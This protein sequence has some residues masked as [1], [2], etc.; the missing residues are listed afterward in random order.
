MSHPSPSKK[1]LALSV[2]NIGFMLDRLGQDCAPL[3]FLRELTQNSIEA[4]QRTPTKKGEVRWDVDWN[5]FDLAGD[6]VFKLAVADTGDGMTGPE[7]RDY[8]NQLSSSITPQSHHGNFGIGAKIAA[9][10]RNHAGLIYLSWKDGEGAMI[11]LWRDP[12]TGQYGLRQFERPDGTFDYWQSIEASV[13]PDPIQDH[14]TMVVLLG[15]R[16]EDHTMKAPE[17]APSPSRWIAKYLN[18]RYFRFPDGI[19]VRAREGWEH[20]R[21]DSDRNLLRTVTGQKAYLDEHSVFSG[22]RELNGALVH[23]WILEDAPAL[24]QNSGFVN[25]NGHVA[26]LHKDELYEIETG[27]G[28][29]ARLQQ[30]GVILGY[31]RVVIYLEPRPSRKQELTTNTA[32]TQLLVNSEPLPWAEWAAEF[33][34]KMPAE[35][36]QLIEATASASTTRDYAEAIRERLKQISDL[37]KLSRYRPTPLGDFLMDEEVPRRGGRPLIEELERRISRNPRSGGK[38]GRAGDV[39]AVF[40]TE[41]GRP[42]SK[43]KTDPFP[44]VMW[45]SAEEGT[46]EPGFLEDRAAKFLPDQNLLQ[47]NADFRVF[48]DMIARWAGRYSEVAGARKVVEGV[49]REWFQQSLIEAVIGVQA[50]EGAREWPVDDIGRALSEEALTAAVMPRYHLDF[51]ISRSLGSKLGS[52]KQRA[53]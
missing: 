20:P 32:R 1:T 48:Q 50:L 31:N 7:M 36:K 3:Q 5:R 39:Y 35:I 25:S 41:T 15:K 49:V 51:A 47:I 40:A 2:N 53:S 42:A 13:K 8:I 28:G 44:E 10:T 9:A 38:G 27:R 30:F 23:W 17:A 4:I 22:R 16:E 12:D 29:V 37:F 34:D 45:V 6:G 52:L 33:R 14:G 21:T 46:R 11:H 24:S 19:P 26:A 43:V 18:T